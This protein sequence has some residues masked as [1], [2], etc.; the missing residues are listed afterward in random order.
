MTLGRYLLRKTAWF[1]GA[2]IVAIV[3]N[4][5]LPRLIP[6]NPIDAI[7]ATLGRGGAEGES[8]RRVYEAYTAEFGLDKPLWEQFTLYIQNMAKG[9]FGV[10]FTLYPTPVSQ[11][12]SDALPWT[13]AL[14]LPAILIGWIVGNVLG[15]VAGYKGGNI[16]RG[17]FLSSLF[18]S[19]MPY[20]C[21]AI[22]LLYVFAV[23][24]QWLPPSGGYSFGTTP[25]FSAAFIS[26]ALEHYWLPFLSLVLVFIGGQAVGM[27]SMVIYELNSDYVNYSRGLGLRDRQIVRQIF[28]NGMLPQV[29]GL[30]LSVGTLAGGA[31][32]T[33]IVFSYPGLGTLL[34]SSIRQNDYPVFFAIALLITVGVLVANFLVD[35]AYGFIDPRIRAASRGER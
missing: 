14:Q 13:I 7:V 19:S 11:L 10:S 27:R 28:R 23:E 25:S 15:A 26:D 5:F 16:D 34:F 2:F 9:D 6:G 33:E 30:A 29:T 18:I 35:V 22:I 4:F 32:I 20:Y 12:I 3:L 31:L 24:L 8:L 1:V 21:L 17:A